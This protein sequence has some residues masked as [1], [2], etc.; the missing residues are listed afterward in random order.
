MIKQK[1]RNG[2]WIGIILKMCPGCISPFHIVPAVFVLGIFATTMLAIFG[3][4]QFAAFM[5]ALYGIFTFTGTMF[6]VVSRKANRY[7][8]LMPML[9]LV[10]HISYGIGTLVGVTKRIKP[11]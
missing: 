4:W 8:V 6:T 7:T 10:L 9:F 11:L 1:Y 3:I 5:W 2:Y